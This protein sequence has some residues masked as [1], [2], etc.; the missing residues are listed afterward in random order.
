M[1]LMLQEPAWENKGQ[2]KEVLSDTFF[3]IFSI[4]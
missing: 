3:F 2:K 4:F 1:E